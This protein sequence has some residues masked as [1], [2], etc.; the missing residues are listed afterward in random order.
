M[1]AVVISLFARSLFTNAAAT[2]NRKQ[3]DFAAKKARVTLSEEYCLCFLLNEFNEV[4]WIGMEHS[5][6]SGR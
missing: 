2:G 5:F 4:Q 1:Y 3:T 6:I